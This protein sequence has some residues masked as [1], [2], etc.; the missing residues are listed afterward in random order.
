GAGVG[1][2]G[3][4][5][6][7]GPV[8]EGGRFAGAQ[9]EAA[10]GGV[11]Q[12]GGAGSGVLPGVQGPAAGDLVV[13]AEVNAVGA[14]LGRPGGAADGPGLPGGGQGDRVQ[15]DADVVVQVP[16]LLL[17]EDVIGRAAG[18]ARRGQGHGDVGDAGHGG[19]PVHLVVGD[20][21]LPGPAAQVED[22]RRG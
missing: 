18:Q 3:D 9:Q 12:G 6:G 8:S 14:R 20:E 1:D 21:H 19:G 10:A 4:R 7:Q 11:E 2:L 5:G 16:A 17:G 15:G 22:R 13:H